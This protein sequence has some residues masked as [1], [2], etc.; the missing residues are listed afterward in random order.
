[1]AYMSSKTARKS[2][3]HLMATLRIFMKPVFRVTEVR[4]WKENTAVNSG[5]IGVPDDEFEFT[6]SN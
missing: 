4:D 3:R 5:F 6:G 1:M 2:I